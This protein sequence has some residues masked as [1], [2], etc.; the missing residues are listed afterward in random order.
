MLLVS[1]YL[2]L[3]ACGTHPV[4]RP[5]LGT[6]PGSGSQRD[7][8]PDAA[9]DIASLA[10]PV[11]RAEPLSKYGNPPSYQVY[12]KTYY[13]LK[14][15]VG[16]V[17]RGIASWYGTKFHGR[18]TSSREPYD[19]YAFTAAHKTLPLPTYVRVTN[20]D[21]NK[22]LVVRVNDRGPFHDDRIIDLSYAAASKLGILPTGTGHVEVRA[23]DPSINPGVPPPQS[24]ISQ[25]P[26]VTTPYDG[27]PA[28]NAAP[29]APATQAS[30]EHTPGLY[31]QIG[32]F[33]SRAN[34]ESMRARIAGSISGGI[35]VIQ[36]S[37]N[38]KP[39][40]RVRLGPLKDP[41]EVSRMTETLT[42]M[43]FDRPQ[44]VID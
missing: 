30:V 35:D 39:I 32:A 33:G 40:Y 11:P 27:P 4:T 16:Y 38:E 24:P 6:T 19:L 1:C 17:E 15:S 14:S 20:L 8:P 26:I 21:N 41:A 36:A 10:E 3:N 12:G 31:L 37:V 5:P 23:I 9:R 29:L 43:G 34:A 2:L 22:S 7:G 44:L 13:P 25:S 42:R 18:S 28:E